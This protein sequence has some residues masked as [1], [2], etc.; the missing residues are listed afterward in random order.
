MQSRRLYNQNRILVVI[1]CLVTLKVAGIWDFVDVPHENAV[2][3]VSDD[4]LD[5]PVSGIASVEHISH[6]DLLNWES[7]VTA[8]TFSHW[9]L[10]SLC[11]SASASCEPNLEVAAD[12]PRR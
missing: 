10:R 3:T 12:S 4:P 8:G 6:H 7:L 9:W 2:E 5:L 11:P 1:E